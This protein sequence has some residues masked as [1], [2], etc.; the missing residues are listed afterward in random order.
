MAAGIKCRIPFLC[1]FI[2]VFIDIREY[3]YKWSHKHAVDGEDSDEEVPHLAEGPLSINKVPLEL[4]LVLIHSAVLVGI[5]VDV[6]DHHFFQVGLGHLLETGLEPQ[7]IVVT[8][9]LLPK[10]VYSLVLLFLGHVVPLSL[11][12]RLTEVVIA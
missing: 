10:L 1:L 3:N 7:L 9:C 11:W 2:P 6:I 8:S 5:L 12:V 4:W